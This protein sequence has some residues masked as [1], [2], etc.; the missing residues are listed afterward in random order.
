[1]TSAQGAKSNIAHD[2]DL[3]ALTKTPWASNDDMN[4]VC[5]TTEGRTAVISLLSSMD[6]PDGRK[7]SVFMQTLFNPVFRRY[8]FA[9]T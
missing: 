5:N 6:I 8:T 3:K 9:Y 2:P 7:A 4:S 1:M